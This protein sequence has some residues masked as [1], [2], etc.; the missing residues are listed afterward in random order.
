MGEFQQRSRG[1]ESKTSTVF[2]EIEVDLWFEKATETNSVDF[3]MHGLHKLSNNIPT[4]VTKYF[5]NSI[6]TYR[7]YW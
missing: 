1:S 3:E 2:P 7:L 4:F 5:T 6:M